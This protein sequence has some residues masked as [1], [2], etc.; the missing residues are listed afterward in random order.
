VPLSG[1]LGEKPHLTRARVKALVHEARRIQSR[2]P[3]AEFANIW[4]TLV[5]LEL[6]PAERLALCLIRGR[7]RPVRR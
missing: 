7:S 6:T 3:R 4:H 5:L 1:L 2:N